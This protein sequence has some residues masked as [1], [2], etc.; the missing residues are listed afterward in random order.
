M[1]KKILILLLAFVVVLGVSACD[2]DERQVRLNT[3]TGAVFDSQTETLYWSAVDN[4]VGY[5]VSILDDQGNETAVIDVTD[6]KID[7]KDR[8]GEY[9]VA[10]RAKGDG[11]RYLDSELSDALNIKVL[12]KLSELPLTFRNADTGMCYIYFKS[13]PNVAEYRFRIPSVNFQKDV[14][15]SDVND[16]INA[17]F[18]TLGENF[19]QY[20]LEYSLLSA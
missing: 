12:E 6:A 5:S 20:V 18:V 11:K 7:L 13:V 19:G 3:P 17:I 1:R 2:R 9:S 16:D 15:A 10:L 4:A 14:D 8:I